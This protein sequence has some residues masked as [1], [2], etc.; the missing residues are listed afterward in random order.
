MHFREVPVQYDPRR[1]FKVRNIRIPVGWEISIGH[2]VPEAFTDAT[3]V[4]VE[5]G[6]SHQVR[7]IHLFYKILSFLNEPPYIG[8]SFG[9][10]A[11]GAVFING[12]GH[13]PDEVVGVR[14]FTPED[15]MHLD[16]FLLPLEGFKVVCNRK[17]VDLRRKFH[18]G[19]PP[20]AVGKNPQLSAFDKSGDPLFNVGEITR[21]TLGPAGNTLCQR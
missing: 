16:D 7:E 6:D 9:V 13:T 3:P 8:Q 2:I 14:V 10:E 1:E 4:L 17:E 15:R 20:V 18:L 12:T 21:G 11:S 19:M 5:G